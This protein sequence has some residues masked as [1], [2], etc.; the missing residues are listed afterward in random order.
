[1]NSLQPTDPRVRPAEVMP[2]AHEPVAA[3]VPETRTVEQ[4]TAH[5]GAPPPV[6]APA[7]HSEVTATDS[8]EVA[9]VLQRAGEAAPMPAITEIPSVAPDLTSTADDIE[10]AFE[11]GTVAEVEEAQVKATDINRELPL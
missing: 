1:M 3:V 7:A 10:L 11:R 8:R 5:L 6:A 9:T 4:P 2:P